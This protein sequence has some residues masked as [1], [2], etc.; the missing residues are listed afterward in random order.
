ML[1]PLDLID[2][3]PW[4]PRT[5]VDD[6]HIA[7]LAASIETESLIHPPVVRAT[8]DGRFQIAVGH[9][10]KAACALLGRAEMECDLRPLTDR[11]MSDMAAAEN[12]SRRDLSAIE[13]ARAIKRRMDDFQ[14]TQLEV[15]RPFGYTDAGTVSNLLR[16]LRLPT[17]AQTLI[18]E[19]ALPERLARQL[20]NL[21]DLAPKAVAQA[22]KNVAQVA[23]ARREEELRGS[24]EAILDQH[25]RFLDHAPFPADWPA[26]PLPV[27]QP[28]EGEPDWLRACEGCPFKVMYQDAAYCTRP[29]CHDLKLERR[30]T[31]LVTQA[32]MRLKVPAQNGTA[33]KP[34]DRYAIYSREERQRLRAL[35]HERPDLGICVGPDTHPAYRDEE[36]LAGNRWV[37]LLAPN[38]RLIQELLRRRETAPSTTAKSEVKVKSLEDLA[39]ARRAE[40]GALLRLQYD[41]L[42]L[43]ENAARQIGKQI[44]LSGGAL[45]YVYEHLTHVKFVTDFAVLDE[46]LRAMHAALDEHEHCTSPEIDAL[47]LHHWL[48]NEIADHVLGYRSTQIVPTQHW[49]HCL[50]KLQELAGKGSAHFA[51]FQ[52]RLTPGWDTPPIHKTPCNCW[53]CGE[54]AGQRRLTKRDLKEGW[55]VMGDAEQPT[56]VCCPDCASGR[57]PAKK[58]RGVTAKG[59]R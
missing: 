25:A 34:I 50:D 48:C 20:V 42:W 30:L 46:A 14:L 23:P 19:G 4:Q 7:D 38:P 17:P 39:L 13:K 27:E 44:T 10:R 49:R 35:A 56:D 28:K 22:A 31:Q 47:R 41:L 18:Q 33:V 57:S 8:S 16:L 36:S 15:A 37:T 29:G 3:N 55:K 40:R 24:I 54:F 2:S 6:S 59:K 26:E 52:A 58:A 51:G 45:L 5:Q 9:N 32:S 43:M 11:Q 53:H 1:I 12:A 21:S